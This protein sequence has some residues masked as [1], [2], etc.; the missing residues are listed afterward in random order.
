MLTVALLV[1]V[2]VACGG[3]EAPRPPS[4]VSTATPRPTDTAGPS[5][6]TGTPTQAAT[7]SPGPAG[8]STPASRPDADPTEFETGLAETAGEDARMLAGALVLLDRGCLDGR[9][10]LGRYAEQ[11]WRILNEQRG[12]RVPV[13]AVVH[14]VI[15]ALPIDGRTVTCESLF[16]SV[17]TELSR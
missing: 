13:A 1:A 7:P 11:T 14:R 8:T 10:A 15:A 9:D 6:P 16:A 5:T 17:V 2:G 4:G 3:D 12:V